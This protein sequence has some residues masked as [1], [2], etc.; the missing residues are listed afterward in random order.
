MN[1][2]A[3]IATRAK[4]TTTVGAARAFIRTARRSAGSATSAKATTTINTEIGI[5]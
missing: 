3:T 5:A 2:S 1:A 4:A